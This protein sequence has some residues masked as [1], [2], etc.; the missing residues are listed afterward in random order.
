[1]LSHVAAFID[2]F[3]DMRFV[4]G[5]RI[6]VVVGTSDEAEGSP[7]AAVAGME[8]SVRRVSVRILEFDLH[9]VSWTVPRVL[10][11]NQGHLLRAVRSEHKFPAE[12]C[13][14]RLAKHLAQVG[15][16]YLGVVAVDDLGNCGFGRGERFLE[17]R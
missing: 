15:A 3:A 2:P 8:D 1:M 17:F 12:H 10:Q 13:I 11:F 16:S 4:R 9:P 5:G 6:I 14:L 7:K